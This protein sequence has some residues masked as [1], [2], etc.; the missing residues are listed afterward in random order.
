MYGKLITISVITALLQSNAANALPDARKGNPLDSIGIQTPA[1]VGDVAIDHE[2]AHTLHVGPASIKQIRGTYAE[3]GAAGPQC[4]DYINIKSQAYRQLATPVL[5]EQAYLNNDF[6]SNWYQLTYGIPRAN[7]DGLNE[8]KNARKVIN[9]AALENDGVIDNYYRLK[10]QWTGIETEYALLLEER[11]KLD[12]GQSDETTNCIATSGG[13]SNKMYTCIVGVIN[14]YQPLKDALNVKISAIQSERDAIRSSYYS[15][16]GSYDAYK[17]KIDIVS[18]NV[19]FHSQI[20]AAQTIISKSAFELEDKLVKTEGVKITGLASAGYN[21]WDQERNL[22]ANALYNAGHSNY[23]VKQLDVFNVRLNSG[24]TRNNPNVNVE[25]QS[26]FSKNVWSFPADTLLNNNIVSDWSMPFEREDRGDTI[27]FD[28]MDKNSFASGGIDF[29]VTKDARCG[30]Y[31]QEVEEHYSGTDNNVTVS[32]KVIRKLYEPQPNRVVLTANLGLSY[33]YYAYPGP[34]KGECTIDVDRMNSY[35]RNS[36]KSKGWSWFRTKTNSWDNI[37][38][39]ARENLGM[40]CKLDLKPQSNDPA[41][42]AEIAQNIEVQMY[43][44]MWQMFL[45]VYAESYDV[46]VV[47]PE[48][49]DAGES[50]VGATLGSGL[51]KVC[52]L[53]AYC[54]FGNIVLRTLDKIG[55]SKAQGTTSHV[56]T[57]YGKIWKRFEKNTWNVQEGSALVKAKVCVDETQCN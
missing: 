34:I 37:R 27:H 11:D 38:E 52:A 40:D 44:D 7:I 17:E 56:S 57:Q 43:N 53:N 20:L 1:G 6:V 5:Q 41:V 49:T 9:Q 35:W 51:T 14:K 16:K 30:E 15:A 42:A 24:V 3:L 54:Q 47:A 19:A 48:V 45:S 4:A 2:D 46:E 28:T 29:F 31:T 23:S 26:I 33:N 39:S 55:G 12:R 21:L 18:G 10:T 13:D 36:G 25:G 32:W 22:L 8:I 50:D